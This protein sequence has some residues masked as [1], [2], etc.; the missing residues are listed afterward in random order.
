MEEGMAEMSGRGMITVPLRY[1]SAMNMPAFLARHSVFTFQQFCEQEPATGR[2]AMKKRLQRA[3]ASGRVK[4][5]ARGLFAA[6]PAGVAPD[7]FRPDP[8]LVL[9]AKDPTVIFCGHSALE[10]NGLAYSIWHEVTAYR[11]QTRNSISVEG[12]R[13]RFFRPPLPMS[14]RQHEQLGV[15]TVDRQG[16][17]LRVLTPERALVEGFRNPAPFGGY[18][19]LLQSLR[20]LVRLKWPILREVLDVYGERKLYTS[21]GWFLESLPKELGVKPDF[22]EALKAEQSV[23][24]QPLT[25]KMGPLRKVPGWN[26]LVPERLLN[27]EER[28][29][30]ES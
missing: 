6:V 9:S 30:S 20:S 2:E 3:Q 19:E 27:L 15:V 26:L 22:L 12:T 28:D 17:P 8:Y 1:T 10:L 21:V 25:R 24:P 14:P 7:I 11:T 29:A 5:V 23:T 13:Y 18:G 16:F 4:Q